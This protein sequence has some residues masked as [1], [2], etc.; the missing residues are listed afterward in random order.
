[1]D[2]QT[3][4]WF[5][6][7][8]DG[9]TVTEVSDIFGVSQ[10]GV[11][12]ALKALE[13]EVGTAL[14]RRSG[15]VLRL[16]HA[17]AAFKAHVDRL[18]SDLDDGLAAVEELVDPESGV[19]SLAF[20]LSLGTWFVPWAI[21]DFAAHFPR[22]RFQLR[23]SIAIEPGTVSPLLRSRTVDLEL[24]THRVRYRDIQWQ[25]LTVDPL[26]LAVPLGHPLADQPAVELAQVADEPFIMRRAPSGMRDQCLALAVAAG[27]E[28][29]I[30][31]EVDDVPTLRGFVG[32]G[33]GVGLL[34]AMGLQAPA[35]FAALRLIPL[36]DEG[37]SREIG[38]A[39]RPDRGELPSVRRFRRFL[40]ARTRAT[41]P[42]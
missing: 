8:A 19:V 39:W 41:T 32:S 40:L 37:A 18:V 36:R 31:F 9:L 22:V 16:T 21:R 15:R 7:V 23:Q 28:P 33:L 14:L 4:R 13:S 26:V 10:P 11:S 5:Q 27:F 30:A 25:R 3:L 1:M 20:P 12:R 35:T 34:P 17:G 2:T 6:L 24:T 42:A 29:R 38:I